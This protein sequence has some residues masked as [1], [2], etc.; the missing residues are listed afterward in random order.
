[1]KRM[2]PILC[3][4]A[5][6]AIS[7]SFGLRSVWFCMIAGVGAPAAYLIWSG[8]AY[9]YFDHLLP[10]ADGA[11]YLAQSAAAGSRLMVSK[12]SRPAPSRV[13]GDEAPASGVVHG[14]LPARFR[15]LLSTSTRSVVSRKLPEASERTLPS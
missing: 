1:M 11:L 2:L 10:T 12:S 3:V 8:R 6:I 5:L 7:E 14:R 13:M 4:F 9:A 15:S